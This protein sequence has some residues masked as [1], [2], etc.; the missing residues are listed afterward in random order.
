MMKHP[1][2]NIYQTVHPTEFKYKYW[3]N[4][5]LQTIKKYL[6]DTTTLL[7][8]FRQYR[9]KPPGQAILIQVLQVNWTKNGS[10]QKPHDRIDHYSCHNHPRLK[11]QH[12]D[13]LEYWLMSNM[14][15][16]KNIKCIQVV[17]KIFTPQNSDF[18]TKPCINHTA[19]LCLHHHHQREPLKMLQSCLSTTRK[20]FVNPLKDHIA[21]S[22]YQSNDCCIYNDGDYRPTSI[23]C[24]SFVFCIQKINP[25]FYTHTHQSPKQNSIIFK[26]ST[27]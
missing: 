9:L 24:N 23:I 2:F 25:F 19:C 12:L 6:H 8:L 26:P 11:I 14:P 27:R 13:N 7:F 4:N 21:H 10:F 20:R 17:S 22:S 15:Q 3:S 5:H 16:H 1:N 18:L